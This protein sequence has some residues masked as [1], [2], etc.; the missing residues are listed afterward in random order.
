MTHHRGPAAGSGG[1]TEERHSDGSRF[2]RY[3]QTFPAFIQALTPLILG[4]VIGGAGGAAIGHSSSPAPQPT[5]TVT[6]TVTPS[7]PATTSAQAP[8]TPTATPS[9]YWQGSVGLTIKGLNFDTRPP[10]SNIIYNGGLYGGGGTNIEFAVWSGSSAPNATQ[11]Q[12]Y[13]TTHPSPSLLT[14]NPGMQICIRTDQGRF[15][16]LDIQSIDSTNGVASAQAT[17]WGS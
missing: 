5:V 14:I 4:L 13:V 17:I 15:G 12:N 7:T 10:S 2:W 6:T 1:P 9:V 11:C 8:A 16:L 3:W